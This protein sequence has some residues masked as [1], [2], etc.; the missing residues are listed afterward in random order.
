M[1]LTDKQSA[2]VSDLLASVNLGGDVG[3]AITLAGQNPVAANIKKARKLL[4]KELHK[5]DKALAV[6]DIDLAYDEAAA[7][8]AKIEGKE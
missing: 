6:F 2:K 8:I 7:I 4:A 3:S 5:L 1:Q